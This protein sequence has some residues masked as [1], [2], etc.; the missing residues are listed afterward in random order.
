MN[1]AADSIETIEFSRLIAAGIEEEEDAIRIARHAADRFDMNR[2]PFGSRNGAL[3]SSGRAL[4]EALAEDPKAF[5]EY[6]PYTTKMAADRVAMSEGAIGS[7]AKRLIEYGFMD[8]R[9]NG[10]GFLYRVM[11]PKVA[12]VECAEHYLAA[13]QPGTL[14]YDYDRPLGEAIT[15]LL[16]DS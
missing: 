2:K 7:A 3:G 15:K 4:Y 12:L 1:V 13:D 10:R 14:W 9:R 5:A 11:I 8:K 6:Q 16:A